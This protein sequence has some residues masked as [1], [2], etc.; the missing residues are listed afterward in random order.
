VLAAA[1][2]EQ[3]GVASA[4]NNAA[5]RFAGLIATAVLPLVVGL[6]SSRDLGQYGRLSEGYVRAM[7]I[8]AELCVVGAAVAF[9]TIQ[10]SRREDPPSRNSAGSAG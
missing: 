3:A 10:S 8:G 1:P 5:A 9:R 6:G 2:P 7:W 4:V